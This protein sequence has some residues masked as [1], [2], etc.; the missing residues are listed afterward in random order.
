MPKFQARHYVKIA[1]ML[2]RLREARFDGTYFSKFEIS[3]IEVRFVEYFSHDSS[4]FNSEK[5]HKAIW[6]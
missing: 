4:K 6:E 3:N 2:R 1:K 5:F